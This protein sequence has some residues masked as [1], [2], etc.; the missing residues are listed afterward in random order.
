LAFILAD[1]P[2][3]TVSDH[4]IMRQLCFREIL[5]ISNVDNPSNSREGKI[6][7]VGG[8]CLK[9]ELVRGMPPAEPPLN[10]DDVEQKIAEKIEKIK[11][12]KFINVC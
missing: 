5:I 12:G 10:E 3:K 7:G 11:K 1:I 2:K 8:M 4:G 6:K 9:V